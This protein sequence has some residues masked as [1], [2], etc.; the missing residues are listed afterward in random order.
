MEQLPLT[1][2][3]AHIEPH[4][5]DVKLT[6]L[7]VLDP[8]RKFWPEGIDLD[9]CGHPDSLISATNTILPPDDGLGV[10]WTWAKTIWLN[11]PYSRDQVKEWLGKLA[12]STADSMREG[13]ALINSDHTTGWWRDHV[14]HRPLCLW[15]ERISFICPEGMG[16]RSPST[17]VYFG[18]RWQR[19]SAVFGAHGQVVLP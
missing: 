12:R 19:F 6:P 13:L 18:T 14:R 2:T 7:C 9:P 4:A 10:D 1:H 17:L 11:P 8:V 3:D 5:T 15:G 16:A